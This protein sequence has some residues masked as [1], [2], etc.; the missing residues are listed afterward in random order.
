MTDHQVTREEL[1]EINDLVFAMP[2]RPSS[3]SPLPSPPLTTAA[4]VCTHAQ[5]TRTGVR[6]GPGWILESPWWQRCELWRLTDLQLGL[7]YTRPA[8]KILTRLQTS[9]H[10]SLR[11][12]KICSWFFPPRSPSGCETVAGTVRWF[13]LWDAIGNISDPFWYAL[14]NLC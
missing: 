12:V 4:R 1:R 6:V 14:A 11:I 3:K 9:K 7:R 5:P 10:Q 13:T 2:L 8:A